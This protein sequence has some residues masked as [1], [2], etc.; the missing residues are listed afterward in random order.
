[1]GGDGVN[2]S[3]GIEA[4]RCPM[5][6]RCGWTLTGWANQGKSFI[7]QR[8]FYPANV[9][10]GA[11]YIPLE[12]TGNMMDNGASCPGSPMPNP[13]P[14]EGIVDEVLKAIHTAIMTN[15]SI[16]SVTYEHADVVWETGTAMCTR[17]GRT[18]GN[19]CGASSFTRDTTDLIRIHWDAK[20]TPTVPSWC[21]TTATILD[22]AF[23][24]L[25]FG[26]L[27]EACNQLSGSY[28]ATADIWL[29]PFEGNSNN[30]YMFQASEVYSSFSARA[31][32]G[33]GAQTLVNQLSSA[34]ESSNAALTLMRGFAMKVGQGLCCNFDHNDPSWPSS[35]TKDGVNEDDLFAGTQFLKAVPPVRIQLALNLG[36]DS[37]PK[38][39]YFGP[40]GLSPLDNAGLLELELHR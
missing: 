23:L 31:Y 12:S 18:T 8:E 3:G 11:F 36:T 40:E 20:I 29:K 34:F 6:N 37:T 14:R 13:H 2:F 35:C 25:D 28:R 32:S 33:I 15:S 9:N 7:A 38:V 26:S 17:F 27:N 4:F 22:V 10:A 39:D 19:V 30:T 24:G 21:T 5:G 1:M 16:Q